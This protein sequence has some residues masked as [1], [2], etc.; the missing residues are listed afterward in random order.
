MLGSSC[1]E[2][3]GFYLEFNKL[4]QFYSKFYK[5]KTK[6]EST[7][8]PRLFLTSSFFRFLSLLNY[9]IVHPLYHEIVYFS[10]LNW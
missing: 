10:N 1:G 2:F 9:Q 7:A 5:L 4:Q 8:S 6:N 3:I